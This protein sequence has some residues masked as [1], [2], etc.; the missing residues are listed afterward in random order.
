MAV[1][2]S[3]NG[4]ALTAAYNEVVDEKSETNWV[5]FTYEGNTNDIRLAEKGDG[6]LEELIEELNSGKVMYAFCRVQDPN[7]GL[8]KY[9]LIN[10]TG[11]GVKDAR[12]GQCA[13]HVSAMAN[14]LKG[15]HVTINARAEEDVEPDAI[16]QKVAKASGANYSFHKESN[17]FR[18]AG[19]QGPVGSVYQK[20]NAMSEIKR[21][22][23]DTFWAQ[24]EKDEEKRLQEEK[25]KAEEERL[26][27][28]KERK[29]REVK[30]AELRDRRGKERASQ[31]D[32]QRKYQQKQ[33]VVSQAQEKQQ[34]EEQEREQT[35]QQKPLKRGESVEKANRSVNP[36]EMFKQREMGVTPAYTDNSQSSPKPESSFEEQPRSEYVEPEYEPEPEYE[37]V[38]LAGDHYEALIDQQQQQQ[39]HYEA[40]VE[41]DAIYEEAVQVEEQNTY[42]QAGDRGICARALY[43][44][45]AADD[46]EISFDP[47]NIIT[48]I[49]MIDEGW[50]RGY[51]PDGHFGMFPANYVELV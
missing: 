29:D 8:P 6:G 28:E 16:M 14:F 10:W 43:D 33:E 12:K 7:S 17:R 20:T 51:S 4:P 15:A 42:E 1:N 44:Y 21:T 24:A 46:T 13:S 18:D 49:E 19:P 25:R 31:I 11:E 2:L 22:N 34:W 36:R 32:E 27:L 40:V 38:Q 45:Q 9:V 50:W 47:D 37:D 41:P 48:G 23:K 35:A 26:K 30:E 5:L 3:K 39:P